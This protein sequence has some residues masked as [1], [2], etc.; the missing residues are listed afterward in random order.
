MHKLDDVLYTG[1]QQQPAVVAVKP[2]L[3]MAV[4]QPICLYQKVWVVTMARALTLSRCLQL[5]MQPAL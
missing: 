3:M 5:A 1:V 2:N 4:Y